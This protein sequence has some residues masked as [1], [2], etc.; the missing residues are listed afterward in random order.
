MVESVLSSKFAATVSKNWERRRLA[1]GLEFKLQLVPRNTLKR[2][3]QRNSP[4]GR[5]RSR[6]CRLIL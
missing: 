6:V 3:L 1:G 2:E 4:P 5:R